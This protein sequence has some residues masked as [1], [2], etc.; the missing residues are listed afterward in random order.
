MRERIFLMVSW[1][2]E[3]K[4][5]CEK[6]STSWFTNVHDVRH[7]Y[8]QRMKRFKTVFP[9]ISHGIFIQDV[10]FAQLS[11]SCHCP[12]ILASSLQNLYHKQCNTQDSSTRASARCKNFICTD[13]PSGGSN[14][15][16][17]TGYTW[18]SRACWNWSFCTWN[19]KENLVSWSCKRE[20]RTHRGKCW[21]EMCKQEW[22]RVFVWQKAPKQRGFHGKKGVKMGE[23][24]L[25]SFVLPPNGSETEDS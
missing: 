21:G 3:R 10:G 7:T 9:I 5:V 22:L 1:S 23:Y 19:V 8:R 2:C 12:R 6:F 17:R 20:K 15:S 25:R 24:H 13:L 18:N 14:H 4:L 11:W 16:R